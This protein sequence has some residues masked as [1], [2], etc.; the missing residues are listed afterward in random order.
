MQMSRPKASESAVAAW[1]RPPRQAMGLMILL[2]LLAFF[3]RVFRLD[4]Q[5]LWYDELATWQRAV[6][7]LADMFADLFAVRNHTPLY[8]LAMRPWAAIGESEFILRYFSVLWGVLGVALIY[9]LG[10]LVGGRRTGLIAT[11]LLAI[12]P[13]HIWYSQEARMYA[14][15]TALAIVASWCL[16]LLL[17]KE[18]R[19]LWLVYAISL[20]LAMY[21]HFLAV[22]LPVAHYAFLSIHYQRLKGFFRRWLVYAAAAGLISAIWWGAIMLTGGFREA[23]ISWIPPAGFSEP[24][25]SILSLTIG[26]S[27]DRSQAAPYLVLGLVL[28]LLAYGLVRFGRRLPPSASGGRIRQAM[29]YRLLLLWFAIPIL[30]IYLISLDLPIPQKRS[31]YVD[32]YLMMTLP[33]LLLATAW[34]LVALTE[35]SAV[36]WIRPAALLLVALVSGVTL[37]NFYVDPS[38]GREDW[39]SALAEMRQAIQEGDV[40]LGRPD[41]V[42]PLEYYGLDQSMY[43]ELPAAVRDEALLEAFDVEMARRV[44]L[45]APDSGRAWLIT[46]FYINDVHGFPQGRNQLMADLPFTNLQQ[47]WMDSNFEA[48]DQQDYVGVRLTLY[49][50]TSPLEDELL[51]RSGAVRAVARLDG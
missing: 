11:F 2:L 5:S 49:D 33:G 40:I 30:L 4:Q 34:S 46:Q 12:S 15:L 43:A 8:F 50:L 29:D 31:L 19:A 39:R 17:R 28:A 14:M 22:F 3:L 6:V 48:I 47:L 9:R 36:R 45:A 35:R 42:L 25:F 10:N 7:P 1:R 18:R 21:T 38:Y 27:I 23:P 26:P 20:T 44:A 16:L 32:R 13:F 24:F 51:W 41:Y 37:F